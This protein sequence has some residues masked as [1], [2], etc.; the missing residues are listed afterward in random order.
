MLSPFAISS[1]F[2][3]IREQRTASSRAEAEPAYKHQHYSCQNAK[4]NKIREKQLFPGS[5]A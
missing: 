3:I 5:P 2:D 4:K 1:D